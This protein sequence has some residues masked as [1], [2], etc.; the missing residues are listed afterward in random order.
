MRSETIVAEGRATDQGFEHTI[1]RNR[2]WYRAQG[3]L[4]LIAGVLALI[5]PSAAVI[6]LEVLLAVL[7]LFSGGYK[8]YQ[9][10]VDR[11]GWLV[12]SGLLSIVLGLALIIMPLA[13][14][15]A[16]ATLIAIFLLVEGIVEVA[17]SL[18]VRSYANSNWKWLLVSGILSAA[19]GIL[20]L[21][22]WPAQTLALAGMLLAVNFLLYGASILAVTFDKSAA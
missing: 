1:K 12:I 11:S 9:G 22:G 17:L 14:A 10:A 6:G 18:Q 16:L 4:L 20:L 13:G 19:L 15:I 21:V 7:L 5:V 2:T 3:V 8:G